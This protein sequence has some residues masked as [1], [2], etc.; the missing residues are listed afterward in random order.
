MFFTKSF[1]SSRITLTRNIFLAV[2]A[3][4]A[5]CFSLIIAP[6]HIEGDQVHYLKVFELMYG[7]GIIEA[8]DVY[9]ST[10]FSFEPIHF[11]V[12]WIFSNS[13]FDKSIAMALLNAL[14]AVLFC[15]FLF[16]RTKSYIVVSLIFF[17]NYYLYTMFF[18]LE[19]LKVSVVFMLIYMV[20]GHRFFALISGFS[21]LQTAVLMII[22]RVS[23][24]LASTRFLILWKTPF[25]QKFNLKFIIYVIS[26]MLVAALFFDYGLKKFDYYSEIQEDGKV[27]NILPLF[28]VYIATFFSTDHSK[29]QVS[30][31]FLMLGIIIFIIGGDRVNMFAYAGFLYFTAYRS[32]LCFK[33]IVSIISILFLSLY[34]GFK[35]YQYIYMV[36]MFGG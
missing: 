6:Y 15:Q 8:F 28:L 14:L 12:S 16:A 13:Q 22:S 23:Q 1:S 35:S 18:T 3:F 32:V 10:I 27:V 2:V 17:S 31:Y 20:Y 25:T 29:K 19:K 30:Y 21:H 5:F 11:M 26:S 7:L 33:G 34:L 9:R 4:F 36:I 24:I